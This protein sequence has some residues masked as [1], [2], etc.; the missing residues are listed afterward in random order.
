VLHVAQLVFAEDELMHL[1]EGSH[2]SEERF[3]LQ[4]GV[5]QDETP[6]IRV[7]F[8]SLKRDDLFAADHLYLL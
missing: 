5:N 8:G 2:N 1:H 4:P 7:Q 3:P 6:Q